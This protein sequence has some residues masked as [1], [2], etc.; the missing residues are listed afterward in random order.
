MLPCHVLVTTAGPTD[1][2]PV[3]RHWMSERVRLVV[4]VVQPASTLSHWSSVSW[5]TLHRS[6]W[7]SSCRWMSQPTGFY[8]ILGTVCPC[9]VICCHWVSLSALFASQALPGLDERRPKLLQ[10]SAGSAGSA[11][12][13]VQLLRRVKD[14]VRRHQRRS[15]V[16]CA[17]CR[18]EP[19]PARRSVGRMFRPTGWAGTHQLRLTAR[20]GYFRPPSSR[21]T[22]PD[23]LPLY[24]A[25]LAGEL[26]HL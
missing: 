22:E 4:R 21:G 8:S 24:P 19:Q 11:G 13:A 26:Q 23:A 15:T 6:Y 2:P 25:L 9:C 16:H 1:W 18:P 10:S 14:P 7:S 20:L 17:P 5:M 3:S 12:G